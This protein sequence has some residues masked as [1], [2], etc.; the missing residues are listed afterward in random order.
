[1]LIKIGG[2]GQNLQQ[3]F[4]VGELPLIK[5]SQGLRLGIAGGQRD[6]VSP[7]QVAHGLSKGEMLGLHDK[8]QHISPC[9]AGEALV[10]LLAGADLKTGFVV[11][12][13]RAKPNEVL[14]LLA[15]HHFFGHHFHEVGLLAHQL[16]EIG[17][18]TAHGFGGS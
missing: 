3:L 14:P 11:V 16:N 18:Q 12:V 9:P 13:E 2:H 5:G 7:R 4:P 8:A 10:D 17:G 6:V 15:Q 1:M